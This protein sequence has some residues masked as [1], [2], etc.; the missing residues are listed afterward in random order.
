MQL[1]RLLVEGNCG[2]RRTTEIF[3]EIAR[4]LHKFKTILSLPAELFK[5]KGLHGPVAY[6][7][8]QLC[9]T[10]CLVANIFYVNDFYNVFGT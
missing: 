7:P 6:L 1:R 4:I 10:S 8:W 2:L 5:L 9:C 3:S